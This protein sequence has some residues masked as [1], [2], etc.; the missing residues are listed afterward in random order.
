MKK[1]VLSAYGNPRVTGINAINIIEGDTLID[2]QL[3]DG[4]SDVILATR[5]GM[6]IR[7]HETDV[8]EMGRATTGVRGIMPD[9]PPTS[10]SAWSS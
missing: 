10:W 2:V 6:A 1:T 9:A 5:V 4:Q 3:T 8:R 7:F